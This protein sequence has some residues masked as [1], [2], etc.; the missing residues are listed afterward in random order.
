MSAVTR[1][2]LRELV[3]PLLLILVTL[4]GVIWLTQSLR[5]IDKIVANGLSV[6]A[7]LEFTSLLAPRILALVLPIAV[8]LAVLY[9]YQKLRADSELIVLSAAG[10]SREKLARPAMA[11]AVGATVLGYALTLYLAPLAYRTFKDR[12]GQLRS[13]IAA[14]LLQEGTFNT[15]FDGLTVYVRERK[16]GGEMFG[17]LVHD[18][19]NPSRPIT[20]MAESGVLVNGPDGPRFVMANGNRQEVDKEKGDL[21]LLYFDSYALDLSLYVA[22][23]DNRWRTPGE[24]FLTGLF[25]PQ[26]RILDDE[27]RQRLRLEGHSRLISPLY[28]IVLALIALCTVL[29]GEFSRRGLGRRIFLG[30][31]TALVFEIVGVSLTVLARQYAYLVPILYLYVAASAVLVI[32]VLRRNPRRS[33]PASM[34]DDTLAGTH[35]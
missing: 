26:D 6:L 31:A 9:T 12:Q 5:F 35:A 28:T 1:Y 29:A 20:M 21:S 4:S 15:L 17:I 34:P 7:F 27:S 2:I 22:E 18:N 8:F 32:H 3:P 16:P 24:R 13:D 19:R 25:W 30:A 14:I 10:F 33:T 11:L 23:P